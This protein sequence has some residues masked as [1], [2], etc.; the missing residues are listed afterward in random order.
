MKIRGPLV[1]KNN[2]KK[3]HGFDNEMFS[4]PLSHFQNHHPVSSWMRGGIP[5]GLKMDFQKSCPC[6][7]SITLTM[8][9]TLS[10]VSWVPGSCLGQH[11][12]QMTRTPQA[13]LATESLLAIRLLE[14]WFV[15]F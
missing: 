1:Q 2:G 14:G 13:V 7:H 11:R 6:P 9:S 4:F 3:I 8:K 15:L 5:L 10:K 12:G